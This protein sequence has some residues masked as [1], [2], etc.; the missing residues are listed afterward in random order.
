MFFLL[1]QCDFVAQIINR[2]IHAHTYKAGTPHLIKDL[3]IFALTPRYQ[4]RKQH[5][6]RTLRQVDDRVDNLLEGLLA[7]LASR[8]RTVWMADTSVQQAQVIIHLCHR[9]DSRTRIVCRPFLIDRESRGEAIDMINIWLLHFIQEL[10]RIGRQRL[11]IAALSF[12]KNGVKGQAT[13]ARAGK[14]RND[15]QLVTRKSHIYIFEIMCAGTANTNFILTHTTAPPNPTTPD[16]KSS[17]RHLLTAIFLIQISICA[18]MLSSSN[19][20]VKVRRGI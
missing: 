12:G 14:T 17:G 4:R 5:D 11:D 2:A 1:V 9:A 3:F 6:T 20:C 10:P 13:L 18:T 15:H 19:R 7:E 8:V 16:D